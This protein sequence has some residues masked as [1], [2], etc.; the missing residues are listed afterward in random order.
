MIY[1]S[2]YLQIIEIVTKTGI[3]SILCI[4]LCQV[5]EYQAF[6]KGCLKER[7]HSE[8]KIFSIIRLI[9]LIMPIVL[10]F[11]RPISLAGRKGCGK[12]M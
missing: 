7:I 2:V 12:G 11:F 8:M 3:F 5:G 4:L 1:D 10:I 6:P 9:L